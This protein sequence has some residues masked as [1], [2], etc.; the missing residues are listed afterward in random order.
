MHIDILGTPYNIKFET[1]S[2]NSK[3]SALDANGIAELYSKELIIRTGYEDDPKCFKNITDF[4]EKVIMHEVFHAIFH[5]C[6]LDCYG[7]DET[8]VN[9]LAVQYPKIER[10]MDS[11]RKIHEEIIERNKQ[12]PLEVPKT[13]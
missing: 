10:I 9:F 7:D 3:L 4:R 5:E 1:D 12:Y 11:A 2:E 13:E 8:L 6:G